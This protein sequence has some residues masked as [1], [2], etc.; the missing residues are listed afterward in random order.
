VPEIRSFENTHASAKKDVSAFYHEDASR[1]SE[2]LTESS[3][4]RYSPQRRVLGGEARRYE[5]NPAGRS[6]R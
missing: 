4:R 5:K 2:G 3:A 6:L 1:R